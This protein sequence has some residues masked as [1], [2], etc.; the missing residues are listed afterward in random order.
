M[1]MLNVDPMFFVLCARA[2]CYLI[3]FSETIVEVEKTELEEEAD[4]LSEIEEEK[5]E[6]EL[7]AQEGSFEVAKLRHGVR[8]QSPDAELVVLP[9]PF[10]GSQD[11]NSVF[12]VFLVPAPKLLVDQNHCSSSTT[13]FYRHYKWDLVGP[14]KLVADFGLQ[15]WSAQVH[16]GQ[17]GAA[18]FHST[19]GAERTACRMRKNTLHPF[20]IIV[21]FGC[22]KPCLFLSVSSLC[23]L[24]EIKQTIQF[25]GELISGNVPYPVDQH[26]LDDPH[27]KANLLFQAHFSKAELPIS[28]Y[29][30]N[31]KSVLDQSIR[32]I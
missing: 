8:K 13:P 11:P 18:G 30:T 14:L 12:Q 3:F 6:S 15:Y 31:L 22:I 2:D 26:H 27:I 9:P 28:D 29:L 10:W 24:H 5:L 32:I 1:R 17:Q 4:V 21:H 20:Q 25:V 16:L 23:M 7:D 19:G